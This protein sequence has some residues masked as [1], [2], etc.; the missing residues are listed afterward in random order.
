MYFLSDTQP[1]KTN[2][3]TPVQKF[4]YYRWSELF[5]PKTF[6]TWQ[7][8]T[9]DPASVCREIRASL[10]ITRNIPAHHSNLEVLINELTNRV[11]VTAL[12]R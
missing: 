4:L 7:L 1:S 12:Q 9:S 11:L 3:S 2:L 8:R 6:L 10:D 5:D